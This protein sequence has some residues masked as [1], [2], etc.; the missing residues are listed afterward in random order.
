VS[1]SD[2]QDRRLGLPVTDRPV[3]GVSGRR[4]SADLRRQQAPTPID[5]RRPTNSSGDR[6]FAAAGPRLWDR[7][8]IHLRQCDS[9]QQFKRLLKTM[10][11]VLGT[12]V[13]CNALVRSAVYKSSY[14]LTYLLTLNLTVPDRHCVSL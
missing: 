3:T 14:L 7:L 5:V 8:P 10:C 1:T 11:L 9:L 2:L 12:A 6:C 13:L 4:L